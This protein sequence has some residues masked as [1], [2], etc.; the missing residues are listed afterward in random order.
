MGWFKNK[1]ELDYWLGGL[2]TGGVALQVRHDVMVECW[3]HH[4]LCIQ[5]I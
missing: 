4:V 2:V 1:T 5:M 3:L